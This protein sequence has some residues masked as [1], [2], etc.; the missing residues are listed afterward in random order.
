M[1]E[2]V[3]SVLI[4]S[5][6]QIPSVALM[7]YPLR[8]LAARKEI[9]WSIKLEKDVTYTD[10]EH[11]DVIVTCRPGV[12]DY[13]HLYEH[14]HLL[15]I[16]VINVQ[17]DYLLGIPKDHLAF[18]YISAP[19]RREYLNWH[20]ESADYLVTYSDALFKIFRDKYSSVHQFLAPVMCEL[21]P[22]QLVD[23]PAGP[24]KIV[25]ATS[26]NVNDHMFPIILEDLKKTLD[27]WGDKV[28]LH[29]LGYC[30]PEF[31]EYPQAHFYPFEYDYNKFFYS[32]SREG[33]GIGLAP[34]K[35]GAFYDCKTNNKF[36]E[37]AAAGAVGIYM[38]TP[39][40]N[41]QNTVIEGKTGLLVSGERGSWFKAISY[42]LKNPKKRFEIR[43]NA[44]NFLN[45]KYSKDLMAD[46]W[47]DLLH[48]AVKNSE[49]NK[50]R[51]LS[52]VPSLMPTV[53]I[54]NSPLEELH[55]TGEISYTRQLES[56]TSIE[57]IAQAD[58]VV[59]CR[60][61]DD[62]KQELYDYAHESNIPV[63]YQI[64]DNLIADEIQSCN[65][66]KQIKQN[67]EQKLKSA[68]QVHT[69]M[70]KLFNAIKEYNWNTRLMTPTVVWSAISDDI[71][72]PPQKP[73][74]IVYATSR[75]E[76]DDIF[77][78]IAKDLKKLLQKYSK[79]I[80]LHFMGYMPKD[81]FG[82]Q[83]NVFYHKFDS[84][85]NRYLNKFSQSG[86]SVGLAPLRKGYFYDCKSDIKFREFS[87]CGI[88]GVYMDG[89][90]YEVVENNKTG[91]IV[92]G[93][94]GSWYNAIVDLIKNPKKLQSIREHAKSF[95]LEYYS[96]EKLLAEWRDVLSHIPLRI[97]PY[98]NSD[99]TS[100][101]NPVSKPLDTP[102]NH[103]VSNVL[104]NDVTAARNESF[105]NPL[106]KLIIK[107]LD[108]KMAP[109]Y[110]EFR[111]FKYYRKKFIHVYVDIDNNCKLLIEWIY[112]NKIIKQ[113]IVSLCQAGWQ[114]ID[115][116]QKLE[117]KGK[118][119]VRFC[120]ISD[121]D[122]M[123]VLVLRHSLNK[124]LIHRTS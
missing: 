99:N 55:S 74:K 124:V 72:A 38:D 20:L 92:S 111:L 51:V 1:S 75:F 28:E 8:L 41:N 70:P 26:R 40:Y 54:Y 43:Q 112:N 103:S 21:F 64:D 104:S 108:V 63:I 7:T 9:A 66:Y 73:L 35:K 100:A 18:E 110:V 58:V 45:Q 42:L 30:P 39:V 119:S 123:E 22:E 71:S 107:Q 118:L 82:N 12:A 34:M 44:W 115:L 11:A 90:P 4:I 85:Y 5:P 16:P 24:V 120:K 81:V 32:F 121:T 57:D 68:F 27:V 48:E 37:Y 15:R 101:M 87:T 49:K 61:F 76:K 23:S 117:R 96:Q 56:E 33:F 60:T 59:A 89:S 10:L 65:Y 97:K 78:V 19:G 25:Y 6:G 67:I 102:E 46:Q 114:Q 17:D 84:D 105:Q 79:M 69:Y 36:R 122:K 109:L 14:A 53:K 29:F 52:V 98:S 86:F 3:L 77:P 116:P 50:K 62:T 13:K 91:I 106:S 83:K 113:S 94:K 95:A 31:E 93:D 2:K 88:V 47:Y 80:E